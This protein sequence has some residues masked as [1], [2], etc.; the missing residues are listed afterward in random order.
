MEMVTPD[1]RYHLQQLGWSCDASAIRNRDGTI[2]WQ[3]DANR[4]GH[5]ILAWGRTATEA[6]EAAYRQISRLAQV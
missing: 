4:Q 5:M 2:T 6:W 1:R 3:V